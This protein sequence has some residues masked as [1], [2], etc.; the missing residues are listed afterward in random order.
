[1][2]KRSDI[3]QLFHSINSLLLQNPKF[4][5]GSTNRP[6]PLLPLVAKP[7]LVLT[8]LHIYWKH[9]CFLSEAGATHDAQPNGYK[10]PTAP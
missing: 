8:S 4:T 5:T 7:I 2:N 3:L 9:F 10:T 1:M 6:L